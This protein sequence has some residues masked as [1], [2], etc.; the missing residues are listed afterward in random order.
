M[1]VVVVVSSRGPAKLTSLKLASGSVPVLRPRHA[2]SPP[3][4]MFSATHTQKP[5]SR[6]PMCALLSQSR[7]SKLSEPE[8][9]VSEARL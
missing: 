5:A 7:F 2:G 4:N 3:A 8:T 1:V 9:H 6:A